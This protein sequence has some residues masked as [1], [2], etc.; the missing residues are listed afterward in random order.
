M[1]KKGSLV[2]RFTGVRFDD[3]SITRQK[4]G[5][6][7]VRRILPYVLRFRRPLLALLASTAVE[8]LITALSPVAL[9]MIIDDGIVPKRFGIVLWLCAGLLV[10]ALV[11]AAAEYVKA[12]CAGRVGEGLVYTLR[13]EVFEHVQ[14]QPLAFFTR[15]RT[16]ALVSRLDSDIVGARQAVTA[17]LVG[18]FST[19]LTLGFVLAAMFYLSWLLTLACLVV[20]PIFLLPIRL[21]ARRMQR[22]T[23]ERMQ[24]EAEIGSLMNERFN[25]SGAMLTKLYGRPE[26]ESRLFAARTGRLRDLA[27]GGVVV[28]RTTTVLVAVLTSVITTLVYGI[29]GALAIRG[30]LE[31]GTLVAMVALL[32]RLYG[33]VD[34]LSTLQVDTMTTLVSFDRL[35]EVLDL[36]PLIKERRAATALPP[37]AKGADAPDIEFDH[38]SFRYPSAAE[39]SLASLEAVAMHDRSRGQGD[40]TLRELDFHAPA[41][42]LTALVG[43]SGAG[44]TTI[45]HLV[46]RLYDPGEG[47]V[48]IGGRNLR[49]L[50]LQSIRDTVGVVTQ[51]AHLF[52][53]TLR[54]NLLYARPDATEDELVEACVAARVWDT[55]RA[56]PDG[57]DTTVGDRGY[58]LSGGEKQRIALARLLVKA[59]PIVVLDEATAHLDSE[60]E[61][62]IQRALRTALK[63]RTSLVIAHRLSTVREADQIL[64]VEAGRIRERGT[65]DQLLAAEGLYADL[66]RTQFAQQAPDARVTAGEGIGAE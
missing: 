6:G 62:A 44:K 32:M 31:V 25:V 12:W 20:I 47:A 8:A 16:G 33:P 52:H 64:V 26:D 18:A 34:Q 23:R 27:A 28:A 5:P 24:L 54:A 40:W 42:R 50:T 48:R 45:T 30:S 21:V 38:V 65:H 9:K 58:R 29:G 14:R 4:V 10:L 61:A 59:P 63:G 19:V 37:L 66:Y 53:D 41:G 39:V 55:V 22:I 7:T 13:R 11:D 60:S 57:L 2:G 15:A 3:E 43:P 49:D 35:F 46:P 36:E 56:L 17:L 1:A 51:D